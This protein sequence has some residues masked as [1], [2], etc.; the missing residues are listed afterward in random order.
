MPVLIVT[1]VYKKESCFS[2][3][4]KSPLLRREF[5]AGGGVGRGGGDADAV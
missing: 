2:D 4:I 1:E 3:I 5:F